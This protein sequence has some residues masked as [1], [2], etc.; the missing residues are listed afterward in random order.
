MSMKLSPRFTLSLLLLATLHLS[1]CA[2][3]MKSYADPN[4]HRTDYKDVVTSSAPMP[5]RVE[6]QFQRDGKPREQS[7]GVLRTHV[8]RTL[9]ASGAF[10]P[11]LNATSL[12]RVVV[13]NVTDRATARKVGVVTGLSFGLSGGIVTDEYQFNIVYTDAEGSKKDGF[14]RHAMHTAVG[15][16]PLP[17]GF[18]PLKPADAF[19]KIV[20]DAV[21]NFVQQYQS[22][23]TQPG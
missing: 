14:Y 18:A 17:Q 6:V 5:V 16:V 15:D 4:F 1:A 13:N 8:E 21:L 22:E 23:Q 2:P 7:A 3:Q 9:I 12:L 19:S 10:A 11:D 20:E